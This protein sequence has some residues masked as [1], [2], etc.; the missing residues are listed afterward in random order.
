MKKINVMETL[1][2]QEEDF[3]KTI[4][5]ISLN[6]TINLNEQ[7]LSKPNKFYIINEERKN[8]RCLKQSVIYKYYTK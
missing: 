2:K 5:Y 3:F 7:F 6:A 4:Y 1:K 8:S